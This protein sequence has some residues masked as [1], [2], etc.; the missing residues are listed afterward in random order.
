MI[1]LIVAMGRNRVIGQ[2][3]QMPW[4]LPND[5]Q[6]F[7]NTTRGHTVVMGRKT[8]E[9]IGRPLPDRRNIV[10]TRQ[11]DYAPAGVEVVHTLDELHFPAD[12]EVFIIG[13]SEIFSAFLPVADRL[14][15]TYI[16]GAFTGDTFFPP[17][18]RNEWKLI[19][20]RNGIQD[21]KNTHPHAFVTY[22]RKPK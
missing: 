16:E 3:N 20:L 1:S 22:E 5:L 11:T 15:I 19:Y 21:E 2:N 9:S 7:K 14:Y 4:H 8:F 18:D 17:Y 6:H 13:G 10:L 12:E